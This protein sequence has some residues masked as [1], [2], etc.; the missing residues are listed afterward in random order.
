MKRKTLLH[1]QAFRFSMLNSHQLMEAQMT[2]KSKNALT[3]KIHQ[4]LERFALV[5]LLIISD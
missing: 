3:L 5:K 2:R 1:K 4:F